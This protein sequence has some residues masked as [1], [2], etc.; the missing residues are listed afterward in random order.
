MGADGKG[1]SDPTALNLETALGFI[2]QR[3]ER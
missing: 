2:M 1:F 3:S